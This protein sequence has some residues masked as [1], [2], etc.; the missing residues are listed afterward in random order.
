MTDHRFE[1]HA[2]VKPGERERRVDGTSVRLVRVVLSDGGTVVDPTDG[3]ERQRPDVVCALRPSQ[4]ARRPAARARCPSRRRKDRRMSDRVYHELREH[5]AYLKLGAVAEQLAT[6]LQAAE[7][8]KP[9]YTP[10]RGDIT[11]N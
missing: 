1:A 2:A 11:A 4:R 6:A 10:V 3:R 7:H 8:D 5:L 9:S